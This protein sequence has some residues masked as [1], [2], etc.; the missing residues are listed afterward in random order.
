MK[1]FFNLT[2][3]AFLFI[4]SVDATSQ[5]VITGTVTDQEQQPVPRATVMGYTLADSTVLGFALTS[6]EG[7]YT[8]KLKQAGAD[9]IRIAVRSMGFQRQE[10]IVANQTQQFDFVLEQG[11]DVLDEVE[12]R[13][14]P[15]TQEGDTL[16]YNVA[17]FTQQQDE[18]LED[19]LKKMPGISVGANGQI[20]FQGRLINKFYID[21][22]DLLES[23]YAMATQNIPHRAVASVE[24][25]KNHQPVKMLEDVVHSIDPAINITLKQGTTFTGTAEVGAGVPNIWQ[26]KAAPMLFGKEHQMVSEL[27]SNN[28]GVDYLRKFNAINLFDYLTFGENQNE[29][30]ERILGGE[31]F[32][33]SVFESQ[34]INF[35]RTHSFSTNYITSLKKG[36]LKVNLDFYHDTKRQESATQTEYFVEGDTIQVAEQTHSRF[37]QVYFMPKLVY[38]H[39]TKQQYFKNTLSARFYKLEEA[40][41]VVLNDKPIQ[42][43]TDRLF[44]AVG[45]QLSMVAKFGK[46]YLQ[47]N[48]YTEFSKEPQKL[49]VTG[50]PLFDRLS[51]LQAQNMLAQEVYFNRFKAFLGTEVIKKWNSISVSTKFNLKYRHRSLGS[52]LG[53]ALSDSSSLINDLVYS[54][55]IPSVEPNATLTSKRWWISLTPK[56]SYQY[57]QLNDR[58]QKQVS[59]VNRPYLMPSLDIRYRLA[60]LTLTGNVNRKISFLELPDIYSGFVVTGY[61][62]ISNQ[63][64]MLLG[65]ETTQYHGQAAYELL[66]LSLMLNLNYTYS[67]NV[68][69]WIESVMVNQDGSST[70]EALPYHNNTAYT[71][72]I[73]AEA[74]TFVVPLKANFK[75]TTSWKRSQQNVIISDVLNNTQSTIRMYKLETD[76]AM[77]KWMSF[78]AHYDRGEQ[79][80]VFQQGNN[81]SMYQEVIGADLNFFVRKHSLLLQGRHLNHQYLPERILYADFVYRYKLK[82]N[83]LNMEVKVSNLFDRRTYTQTIFTSTSSTALYYQLRPRQVLASIK[84]FLGKV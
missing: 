46:T 24:V 4:C 53:T 62:Q 5:T 10:R 59:K 55:F 15:I 42:Q 76:I 69:D 77:A 29:N 68:K 6:E 82:K 74:S 65:V 35:N 73:Q 66:P 51:F 19:V 26:V 32:S 9:R 67:E 71:N 75:L 12:V 43:N 49:E 21:G 39:N 81:S 79:Q 18:V 52:D 41:E 83:R 31:P 33:A 8:L 78:S 27:S 58:H 56:L 34:D 47:L 13:A 60:G 37:G 30:P 80:T 61:R 57:L 36:D 84:F 20:T 7:K 28:S 16:L 72:S 63:D 3:T 48:G 54:A 44:Y 22:K 2:F 14:K 70:S 38:E 45:N 40:S 64:L 11:T 25:M 17:A 1:F 23:K 50:G